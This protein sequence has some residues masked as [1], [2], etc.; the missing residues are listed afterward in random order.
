MNLYAGLY[1]IDAFDLTERLTMTL[2]G[3]LNIADIKLQDFLGTSLNGSHDFARFD[4]GAGFTYKLAQ[5]ATFY[6][7]YSEANRAPTAGELSCANPASPCLHDTFLVSDPALKQVVARTYETGLRGAFDSAP[8]DGHIVWSL[9]VYRSDVAR[10]ILLLATDVNGFGSFQNAGKT[11]HQGFDAS[12]GYQSEAWRVNLAYSFLDA[13]F[14]NAL[15][16]SSNSPAADASGLIVVHPG[17]T[18]PLMPRNRLT[19]GVDYAPSPGWT[20]GGA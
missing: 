4:P 12:V 10:D 8:L 14:R 19:L 11:R 13:T 16:L 18:L 2:S 17:D 15:T 3:R 7:G 20:V 6:L 5:D 9:G 1:A